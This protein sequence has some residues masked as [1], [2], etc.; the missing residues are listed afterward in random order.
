MRPSPLIL[1]S[2]SAFR[3]ALLTAAGLSFQAVSPGVEETAPRGV[4]PRALARRLARLK[5]EAVA[6]N[7]DEDALVIGSDQ[8]LDLG[9]ELLRKPEDRAQ[10]RRQLAALA[11]RSHTLHTAVALV[12]RIPKFDRCAIET[13][14]LTVCALTRREI[15]AYLDTGE[16]MGCAGG[17][18]IEGRGIALFE[19]VRGDYHAIVGL[20]MLRLLSLLREAGYPLLGKVARGRSP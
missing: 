15:D 12:R 18:R 1:A 9:G 14:R 16:W 20:P 7:S 19:S 6:A 11:G 4:S 10:A 13:V 17:Y 3:R 8:T 5:A 2:T